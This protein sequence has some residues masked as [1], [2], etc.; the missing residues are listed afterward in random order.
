MERGNMV[1]QERQLIQVGEDFNSLPDT[2]LFIKQTKL[3]DGDIIVLHAN[4]SRYDLDLD[5]LVSLFNTWKEMF[6]NNTV[7]A[8]VGI[9]NIEI[10]EK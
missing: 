8:D 10:K 4:L 5:I 3:K 7:M 6:P 1:G 2:D 9:D